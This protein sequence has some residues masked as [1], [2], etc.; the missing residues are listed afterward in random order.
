MEPGADGRPRDNGIEPAGEL[1]HGQLDG[2]GE[3][4][5]IGCGDEAEAMEDG[6]AIGFGAAGQKFV[7]TGEDLGRRL[8]EAQT[9]EASVYA[10]EEDG[11]RPGD[12]ADEL[13]GEAGTEWDGVLDKAAGED[14]SGGL[15]FGV[16]EQGPDDLG[17][18]G[19]AQQPAV[20]DFVGAK[21]LDDGVGV[22][23][24][25]PGQGAWVG[26]FDE[27]DAIGEGDAEGVDEGPVAVKAGEVDEGGEMGGAVEAELERFDG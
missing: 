14:D 20:A 1:K 26:D 2:A 13:F 8:T 17:T 19:F 21:E 22:I 25:R 5:R 3:G 12:E 9:G 18:E 23:V 15:K 27:A 4:A 16:L 24:E 6:L 10:E 7:E 11:K